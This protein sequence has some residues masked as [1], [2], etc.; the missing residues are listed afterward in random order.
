MDYLCDA[1]EVAQA[2]G[3]LGFVRRQKVW[4]EITHGV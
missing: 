4:G 1:I 2:R 3:G